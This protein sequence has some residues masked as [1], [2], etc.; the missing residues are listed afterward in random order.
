VS[1]SI[2]LLDVGSTNSR[3]WLVRD[4]EIVDSRSTGV[5]VRNSAREGSTSTIR[6]AVNELIRALAPRDEPYSVAA[7]GMITSPHGL[8]DVPH[9]AAPAS[10]EDLARGVRTFVD[11]EVTEVPILLVPGVRTRGGE[12]LLHDDV[13]RGEETLALGLVELGE[14]DPRDVLLNAGSHWKLITVDQLGR[15][16][17]SRTSLGGEVV[18][19]VQSGTLLAASLP[20][21]PLTALLPRWLEA[22]ADAAAREG[23]LRAF[24]AVRLLD[25]R[26]ESTADERFAWLAGA[27][28]G[29]D[30]RA[31]LRLGELKA[32]Q[33]VLI[34][35]PGSIPAAWAH[36]LRRAGCVPLVLEAGTVERAFVTGLL[37]ITRLRS[38]IAANR[39]QEISS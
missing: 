27:C 9:V 35:G 31:L 29:E 20:Q 18:H 30:V 8:M 19:A 34:S 11:P 12:D 38:D 37:R 7:A 6:L 2:V 1:A 4:G 33:R 17:R 28:I 25:Q 32:G 26:G 23:L 15:I 39:R 22:G 36:L 13:M 21:G 3:G 5:G 16:E 10:V 24:F 14:M